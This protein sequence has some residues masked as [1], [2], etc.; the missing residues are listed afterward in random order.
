MSVVIIHVVLGNVG[1][2]GRRMNTSRPGYA[3][4]TDSDETLGNFA[5]HRVVAMIVPAEEG[6][7][8]LFIVRGPIFDMFGVKGDV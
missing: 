6:G 1:G 2:H 8:G 5:F 7:V 3:S 4:G